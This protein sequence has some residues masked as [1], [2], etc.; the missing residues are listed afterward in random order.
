VLLLG[1][2]DGFHRGHQALRARGQQSAA[3]LGA[4]LGI[5]TPE[6]HPRQ[7]FGRG[8]AIFRLSSP[9]AKLALL[10]RHGCDFVYRPAFDTSFATLGAKAFVQEMLVEGLAVREIVVG[11]DFRFGR[12]REGSVELLQLWGAELGFRVT[13]MAPI[14]IDGL[15]CSSSAIRQAVRAGNIAAATRLLGHSWLLEARSRGSALDRGGYEILPDRDCIHPP[16]GC[17]LVKVSALT[18]ARGQACRG[19][20]Y[21]SATEETWIFVGTQHEAPVSLP[22]IIGIEFEASLSA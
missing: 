18:P 3:R 16:P 11:P 10:A 17:Y 12:A 13:R 22:E 9:A 1:N 14:E 8:D 20:L 19:R 2:F 15:A 4:P 5:M 7:F 6:P 21:V